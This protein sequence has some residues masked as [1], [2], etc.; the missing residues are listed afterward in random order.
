MY[1]R[2]LKDMAQEVPQLGFGFVFA[3]PEGLIVDVWALPERE[4][5]LDGLAKALVELAIWAQMSNRFLGAQPSMLLLD[6]GMRL[7]GSEIDERRFLMLGF[8]AQA[9]WG[10][11]RRHTQRMAH[12]IGSK[13]SSSP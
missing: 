9:P 8:V 2:K 3:M 6:G 13:P 5:A 7:C 12:N 10:L 1:E 4:A 11:V